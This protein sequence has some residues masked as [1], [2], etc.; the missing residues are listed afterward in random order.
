MSI[1]G[2]PDSVTM[3]NEEKRE[4]RLKPGSSGYKS[5]V[6]TLSYW[7]SDIGAEDKIIL[8]LFLF[9]STSTL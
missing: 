3:S 5:D 9:S 1:A 8:A 2:S 7:S 4:R 6:L